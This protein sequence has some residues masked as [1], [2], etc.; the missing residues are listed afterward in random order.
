LLFVAVTEAA[1]AHAA[2]SKTEIDVVAR[3]LTSLQTSFLKGED[4]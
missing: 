2:R 4:Q 3:W 1:I